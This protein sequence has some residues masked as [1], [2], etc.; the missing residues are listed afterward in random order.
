[1]HAGAAAH[2]RA[3]EPYI[4]EVLSNDMGGAH[5]VDVKVDLMAWVSAAPTERIA[6]LSAATERRLSLKSV[7]ERKIPSVTG[8]S[9]HR[10]VGQYQGTVSRG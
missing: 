5:S 7:I 10:A 1:M 4:I 6:K 9:Q 2:Q 8:P 3:R